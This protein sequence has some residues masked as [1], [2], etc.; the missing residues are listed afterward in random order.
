M[1]WN[2]SFCLVTGI[3]L[4]ILSG[5]YAAYPRLPIVLNRFYVT[6]IVVEILTLLSDVISSWMDMHHESFPIWSLTVANMLFFLLFVVRSYGLY[7]Y[8]A[9]LMGNS[10]RVPPGI[11]R[12]GWG[13]LCLFCAVILCSVYN[14]A[15]FFID[16]DGYHSGPLYHILYVQLFLFLMMGFLLL[17]LKRKEISRTPFYG[18]V[19]IYGILTVGGICRYIFPGILLMDTFFMISI[20]IL[21][22]T[23]HNADLYRES[24]TMSFDYQAFE[25]VMRE[26]HNF[27]IWYHL[28]GVMPYNYNEFRQIYGGVQVDRALT[29]IGR[30][31]H[32]A[33]REGTVFYERS[34]CFLVLIETRE[35][36]NR[37]V[38]EVL[39]GVIQRFRE[40][41]GDESARIYMNFVFGQMNA[42]LKL[43]SVDLGLEVIRR[44]LEKG[45][46]G[47]LNHDF[48][49]DRDMIDEIEREFA[50]KKALSDALQ[51]NTIQVYLQ[52]IIE[53]KTGKTVGA[54]AL[55]RLLDPKLGLIPPSEFIP[56]AERSGSIIQI[57][58]QVLSKTCRF[59]NESGENLGGLSFV[60]INLS[61][62]QCMDH[63]LADTFEQIPK[64]YGVDPKRLHLEITEES[65]VEPD[66]LREQMNLLGKLGYAFAL[67][68]YGS[69]YANQFQ[70]KMFPFTGIKLDMKIVQAHFSDPDAILPNAVR[71]F[72]NRGLVVTAEGVETEEMAGQLTEM[73][74]TYLQGFF[75]SKPL[76]MDEF[77][78][79]V[80]S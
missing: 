63:A 21:Y 42:D 54:E 48:I 78:K 64:S 40:P 68:D 72:L 75:Y 9:V 5:Y 8:T 58:E 30:T 2:F 70:I 67:D 25:Q 59:L 76:P 60:N 1:T 71:T 28:I 10:R 55:S 38:S 36:A 41:W 56:L 73:G 49:V 65:L 13:L 32:E 4:L 26:H 43:S 39:P 52:P 77:V 14:G 61:P 6:L 16:P 44:L 53:A 50:V 62:I 47:E 7:A 17:I 79:Y 34:G 12:A 31:L 20:M 45:G 24:R 74:C 23:I 46:N 57:G 29:Q 80:N 51:N 15:V 11:V 35:R 66:I 37:V 27:G 22:I 18:M 69:G 3:V 19:L 33:F